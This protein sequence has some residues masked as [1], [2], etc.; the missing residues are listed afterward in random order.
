MNCGY[1]N[2]YNRFC[3]PKKCPML[4]SGENKNE[5]NTNK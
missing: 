1:P 4:K 5:N 3:D 2:C